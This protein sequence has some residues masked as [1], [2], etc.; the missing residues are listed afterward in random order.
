MEQ[1][2]PE[3]E[4]HSIWILL[5]YLE[6]SSDLLSCRYELQCA[7]HLNSKAHKGSKLWF[8]RKKTGKQH[9]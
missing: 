4:L 7:K 2:K 3:A 6:Q 8:R 5:I 1:W 9:K